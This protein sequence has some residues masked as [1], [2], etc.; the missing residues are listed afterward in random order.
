[1]KKITFILLFALICSFGF[2]QTFTD[3]GGPYD[4]QNGNGTTAATCG[5]ADELALPLT[6]SGVGTLG[7]TNVLQS[8]TIDVTHT[9]NSDVVISLQDPSGTVTVLLID[10]IGG[11]GDDFDAT[12]LEDGAPALPTAATSPVTGTFSPL[13]PLAGFNSAG[14]SADGDWV[15]LVCDDAGGDV[16]TLDSWALTFAPAPTCADPSGLTATPDSATSVDLAW[17]QVGAVTMWDIELVDITA[18]GTATGAPTSTGVSNPTNISGLTAGNDYEVYVRADCDTDGVSNWVGPVAFTTPPTCDVVSTV[19]IDAL[20]DV[21]IDFSWDAPLGS[22]TGYNWEIVEDGTGQGGTVVVSGSTTEPTRNDTSG[23][24]LT[25]DTPYDFWIQTDCGVD[26][27]SVWNGPF[28]FTT[29]P[30]PPPANDDCSGAESVTQETSIVDA[31]SATAT[32]GTIVGAT[33]SGL[34]AEECNGFTGTANDDVW[35]SFVALTTNVNI[36]YEI[37]WD[38]VAILYSGTCGA[39]TVVD[40]ADSTFGTGPQEEI[41]ATGLV[42]GNTYYT[43]IFQW[44]T[45]STAGKTFDLKIWS[46]DTLGTEEF[47]NENAFTYFPNPVKDELTLNAQ[48]DIQTVAVYN[49]LGQEVLRTAPNA[50]ESTIDMNGFSQGA[51]FVKVTIGNVTETIRVL[52]Q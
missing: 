40:C 9:W 42:V 24:V 3:G 38:G 15:L 43:R 13:E 41:N 18:A 26:G 6:V 51:Y 23:N 28:G 48:K 49:M 16:G 35:Y 1:M 5:T 33:D 44:G 45:S 14:I 50:I 46:P 27:T 34:A 7:T 2:A 12:V 17:S 52:K 37:A 19:F 47:E 20:T 36:T 31:A 10:D 8:V 21:S 11:S 32:P 29:Q 22:P 25:L 30:G 39:L 4:M